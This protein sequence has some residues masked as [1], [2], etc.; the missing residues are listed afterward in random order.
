M[1]IK[2]PVICHHSGIRPDPTKG[3]SHPGR[4]LL[5]KG[6]LLERTC[7]LQCQAYTVKETLTSFQK[8]LVKLELLLPCHLAGCNSVSV[9]FLLTGR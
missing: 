6:V 2:S 8:S 1:G 4:Y 3:V 5:G 7:P 9:G